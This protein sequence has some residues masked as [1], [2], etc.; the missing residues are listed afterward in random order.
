MSS[1]IANVFSF[2]DMNYSSEFQCGQLYDFETEV[3]EIKNPSPILCKSKPTKRKLDKNCSTFVVNKV[4]KKGYRLIKIEVCDL[5]FD[6][7]RGSNIIL[8]AQYVVEDTV[9]EIMDCTESVI[10][11]IS[12][13]MCDSNI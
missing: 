4:L 5:T 12:K 3:E 8:S 1:L 7:N 9:D 6:D 2:T 13:K 11:K 10:R